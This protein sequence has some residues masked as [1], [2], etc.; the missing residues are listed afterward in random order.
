ML[1]LLVGLATG[2]IPSCDLY[3]EPARPVERNKNLL[4]EFLYLVRRPA[5]KIAPVP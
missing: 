3:D 5:R 2:A 1:S 4:A